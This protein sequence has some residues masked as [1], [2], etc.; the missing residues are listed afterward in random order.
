MPLIKTLSQAL[1]WTRNGLVP[2]IRSTYDPIQ[3]IWPDEFSTG[4]KILKTFRF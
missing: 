4:N 2:K 1:R 3:R